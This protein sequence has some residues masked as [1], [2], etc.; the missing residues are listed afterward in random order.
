MKKM[1]IK[2][3]AIICTIW[4][5]LILV[6]LLPSII[7]SKVVVGENAEDFA[8]DEN[9][10][11]QASETPKQEEDIQTASEIS[12]LILQHYNVAEFPEIL[13]INGEDLLGYIVGIV[14]TNPNAN[15]GEFTLKFS[16]SWNTT[17]REKAND[18]AHNAMIIV[19]NKLPQVKG[20]TAEFD[21]YAGQAYYTERVGREILGEGNG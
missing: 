13:Y 12:E 8:P 9:S 2:L 4:L 10:R 21:T 7:T 17:T 3:L 19:G 16:N 11:N 5:I 6:T 1:L 18:T 14:P 20:I 15:D